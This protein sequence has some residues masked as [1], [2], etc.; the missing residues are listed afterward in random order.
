MANIVEVRLENF[1][2]HVDTTIRFHQG[3][4]VIVGQSDSG[5]TAILRA[6]RWALY[7]EP[8]GT[9]FMRVGAN[10]VRVTVAFDHGVTI[11]RERTSSKN[12]YIIRKEG[13]EDLILEGFGVH[14]PIEVIEAHGMD[15][16]RIDQDTELM[17]HLSQQLDGPFL[18]EQSNSVRAKTLGRISGAHYLDIAVRDTSRD[19]TQL[20]QRVRREE[21]E[22][23]NLK[24]KLALYDVLEPFKRQLEEASRRVRLLKE[25]E[26][27][28]QQL[29][30]W[31]LIRDRVEK[32]ITVTKRELALVQNVDAWAIRLVEI[33]NMRRQKQSLQRKQ[34]EL[35]EMNQAIRTYRRWLEKTQHLSEAELTFERVQAALVRF[36]RLREVKAE[37]ARKEMAISEVKRYKE[38]T[39]FVDYIDDE[40]ITAIARKREAY[41]RLVSLKR[42]YDKLNEERVRLERRLSALKHVDETIRRV[43]AIERMLERSQMLKTTLVNVRQLERRIDDGR[44]FI[45]EKEREV[46]ELER[47]YEERL[48]ALG[49]CPTCGQKISHDGRGCK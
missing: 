8:R 16:L 14:V 6:I 5:K 41:A 46:V 25:N 47:G 2:S 15:Y 32:E 18:L 33:E 37:L 3:L 28:R 31:L 24:E 13:E 29:Q 17:I 43:E 34:H 12:R 45:K 4:N 42:E 21:E 27:K 9:E 39:A 10:F 7:N 30:N 11:I 36:N 20:Y 35:A 1:Q 40:K 19:L 49:T 23:T 38:K 48:R 26:K 44:A 22:V